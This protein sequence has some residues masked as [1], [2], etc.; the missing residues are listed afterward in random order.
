MLNYQSPDGS[1]YEVGFVMQK[2]YNGCTRLDM[3]SPIDGPILTISV[4]VENTPCL[5]EDEILVKDYSE[6][7]GIFD[8]MK[9]NNL[10]EEHI[11]DVRSGYV[12]LPYIYLN[13]DEVKKHII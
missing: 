1:N 11:M 8:W 3:V 12:Q 9:K 5:E 7:Q 4:N 2:Y 10:V 6:N 13:M